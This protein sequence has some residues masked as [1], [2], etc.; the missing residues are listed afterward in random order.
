VVSA[1]HRLDEI[2]RAPL[3]LFYLEEHSYRDI[4]DILEVP[5]GTVMSRISRGK[6]LLRQI[7]IEKEPR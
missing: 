5:V 3:A 4:A 1:L 2:Y 6:E 7:F